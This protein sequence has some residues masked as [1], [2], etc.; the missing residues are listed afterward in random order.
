MV[1]VGTNRADILDQALTR[2]GRFDCQT[3][4]DLRNLEGRQKILMINLCRIKLKLKFEAVFS[5]LV[6]LVLSVAGFNTAHLCNKTVIQ[7]TYHKAKS[8]TMMDFEK[9][10]N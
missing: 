8:I 4:V 1:F 6:G 3:Q 9:S 2:L 10:T 5:R 7:V